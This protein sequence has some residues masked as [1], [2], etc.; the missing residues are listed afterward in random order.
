[1]GPGLLTVIVGLIALLST[2]SYGCVS[3]FRHMTN[4]EGGCWLSRLPLVTAFWGFLWQGSK[5]W[6]HGDNLG[7]EFSSVSCRA[8]SLSRSVFHSAAVPPRSLTESWVKNWTFSPSAPVQCSSNRARASW[9][10]GA[11]WAI[12][13][14]SEKRDLKKV[15]RGSAG[16]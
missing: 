1:M 9:R 12:R 16:G 4:L 3:E 15:K 8:F 13:I 7:L 11:R 10:R 14:D 2:L 5:L 6:F